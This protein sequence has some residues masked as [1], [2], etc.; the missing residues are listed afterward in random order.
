MA[1][2]SK[3]HATQRLRASSKQA[4]S[5]KSPRLRVH[6]LRSLGAVSLA[7]AAVMPAQTGRFDLLGPK[8]DVH[9]TRGDQ[10]L[11]IGSVPN[12][13][14]G[15]KLQIHADLPSTQSVHL[16]LV[17]AFLRGTTNPPPDKWFTRVETWKE[18]AHNEGVTVTVPDEAQQALIFIAPETGGD[19][20]TLKSAV[21]GRPGTFVRASQDLNEASFE[22]SRIERYAQAI[23]QVPPGSPAELL[24]HSH[25]LAATL[26]LKPNEECFKRPADLQAACLSQ[27]GSELLLDDGHG[28]TM[29]QM[30]STG[31]TSDLIGAVAGTP[32]A[33]AAGVAAYS[34]YVGTVLDVVR[35]L[36]G[37][38]TAK[39]QYIPAIAFPDEDALNLRLNTAPSF[40]NP[41]S[42]I[43]IALPAIQKAVPPPL[44]LQDARHVSCLL[45]PR[46]V[47]PLLGAPLVFA[48][49]FAH[50]LTLHLNE[51]GPDG[52]T[53]LPLVPD[54]YEGG[55]LVSSTAPRKP[56]AAVAPEARG[57]TPSTTPAAA[58]Q[59]VAEDD[60]ETA[61]VVGAI[62]GT[63]VVR[64]F[65]GFD[66]FEGPT[67]ALQRKPGQDWAVATQGDLFAGRSNNVDLSSTGVACVQS[68]ELADGKGNGPLEWH[69][70]EGQRPPRVTVKL[71]L[72]KVSPGGLAL[73]IRQYGERQPQKVPV[74][75]YAD[76]VRVDAVTAHAGDAFVLVRGSGLSGV[77][78][79]DVGGM[80]FEPAKDSVPDDRVL[81]LD[82]TR[83][84]LAVFKAGADTTARVDLKDGRQ[85]NAPFHVE[86]ARPMLS[87]LNTSFQPSAQ[88]GLPITLGD[89]HAIPLD[90]KLTLALRSEMPARF[91]RNEKVE[92]AA[93]DGSASTTLSLQDKTLVLQ[94]ARTAL[95]YVK[96][97]DTF[98]PSG[99]G[100]LQV[101]A[102]ASDGT[103]SDWIAL[104]I[105]TRTPVFQTFSCTPK[106]SPAQR[107]IT[108]TSV[109][110]DGPVA[111]SSSAVEPAPITA[112]TPCVLSGSGLY[113][114]DAVSATPSFTQ[115]VAVPAGFA[116]DSV[117]VP[118]PTDGH[119]LYLRLR[120]D[121]AHVAS[122]QVE[123]A[124]SKP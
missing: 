76:A 33:T 24:D 94:D 66:K 42:V 53:D 40:N 93:V 105:L 39:Y 57:T 116:Q 22:Q 122:V 1:S 67:L 83:E 6:R 72:E 49:G 111:P 82:A 3:A 7:L 106:T 89:P 34:A 124:K 52:R 65:W 62:Q 68:V 16:L 121:P 60:L 103:V 26:Q 45:Q 47:L 36:T 18:R 35:L 104:G 12:L 8:V 43:V 102:L 27:S 110:T 41:K 75:A 118:R 97:L 2:G 91:A 85:L 32:V 117:Q 73:A 50:D 112:P 14:A 46:L 29:A 21:R 109:V 77:K 80:T 19:F 86:A 59:K 20:S 95:G 48:T 98:G 79:V 107:T 115:A 71:P 55:L 64:G 31:P 120:D 100:P 87:L 70:D 23:R 113:L 4:M 74:T 123:T 37:L 78:N 81:R 25:K 9:V 92:V 10:S 96:P 51:P 38:H 101:R 28:Q 63:G 17:V 56:L 13:Q 69:A 58:P 44:Q 108:T 61:T 15:D 114:L 11:P 30:L 84:K 5:E 54:A 119:T 88:V 99:F 90:G